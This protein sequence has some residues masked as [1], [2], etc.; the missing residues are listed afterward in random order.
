MLEQ[1]NCRFEHE[2]RWNLDRLRQ[3]RLEKYVQHTSYIVKLVE[4]KPIV[5]CMQNHYLCNLKYMRFV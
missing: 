5:D 2:L 3:K 4:V 1:L